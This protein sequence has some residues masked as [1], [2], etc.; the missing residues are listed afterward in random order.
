MIRNKLPLFLFLA[1][2]AVGTL[3]AQSVQEMTQ[4]GWVLTF[5]DEFGGNALDQNRW[6]V[7][8][9]KW[10]IIN[11]ELEAYVPDAFTLK[12]GVLSINAERR[13]AEYGG[14]MM[15][16]TSGAITTLGKFQQEYGYFEARCKVP[17]GK[18][19]WPAFW[20]L[21]TDLSWPP[22]IDIF[23]YIGDHKNVLYFHNHYKDGAGKH[24]AEGFSV[25]GG[26]YSLDFHT[27]AVDWEPESIVW[28]VDGKEVARSINAYC[29]VASSP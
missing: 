27:I 29:S 22:E 12:D 8:Y 5:D 23:E 4:K 7:G 24:Q 25:Q 3:R 15:D 28:Y 11:H 17:S 18:G 13:Q 19:F 1:L 21:P 6:T 10:G 2:V 9:N 20:L 16:Y 26:D 14:K